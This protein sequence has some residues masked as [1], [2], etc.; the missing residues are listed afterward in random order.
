RESLDAYVRRGE[1]VSI[2][3]YPLTPRLRERHGAFVTL[4]RSHDLRGCI[5]YTQGIEPLAATVRDNTVNAAARDP[6]F[7][8]VTP[9][10]L[11]E[12]VIEVSALCPGEEPGS[13]F[14]PV[15]DVREIVVGRDGLYLEHAGPRG[16][17]LLLPQVPVEQG[18][19]L[20][21]Y[22]DGIC[23][24]AGAPPRAWETPGAR[25]YRFS[26]HVFGE[27]H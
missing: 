12:I 5:G 25:L 24:K 18:W 26:A 16:G 15:R 19:G 1:Y 22:L 21:E 13:P 8:P 17:G 23:R 20:E 3:D 4:R 7:P 9:E 14:I 11:P 2:E 6:R 10:E 27:N